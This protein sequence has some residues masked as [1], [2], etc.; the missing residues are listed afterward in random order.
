M[1]GKRTPPDVR[2]AG[3]QAFVLSLAE[4]AERSLEAAEPRVLRASARLIRKALEVVS[5]SVGRVG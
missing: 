2:D 5:K 4:V 1:K 3:S